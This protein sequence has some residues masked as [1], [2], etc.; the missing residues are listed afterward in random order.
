MTKVPI[1]CEK[2]KKEEIVVGPEVLV[3]LTV[4]TAI[5]TVFLVFAA[6]LAVVLGLFLALASCKPSELLIIILL[7]VICSLLYVYGL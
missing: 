3:F 4:L 7:S 2:L 6:I 1:H 5:F